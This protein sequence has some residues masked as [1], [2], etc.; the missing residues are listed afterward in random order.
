MRY[1]LWKFHLAINDKYSVDNTI[2]YI[3]NVNVTD[4][5]IY[6][7][8]LNTSITLMSS[9]HSLIASSVGFSI[10]MYFWHPIR[11]GLLSFHSIHEL[12]SQSI[13]SSTK[14]STYIYRYT[15]LYNIHGSN[16]DIKKTDEALKSNVYCC[17]AYQYF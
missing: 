5:H 3:R 1:Y 6:T 11:A 17:E 10:D 4:A 13:H 2:C 8:S 9:T 14:E 7:A 12:L 15:I 16:Y